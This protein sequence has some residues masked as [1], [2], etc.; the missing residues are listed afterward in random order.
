MGRDWYRFHR[1]Q[2]TDA[3]PLLKDPIAVFSAEWLADTFDM[4]VVV[5]IRHPGGFAAS[6]KRLGWTVEQAALLWKLIYYTLLQYRERRP[7][8]TF[9][10][11]EDLARDPV[12]AFGAMYGRLG[13]V[14]DEDAQATI[15]DHSSSGNPG[16][17]QEVH[18]LKR[19]SV[20]AVEAWRSQ[21]TD[22]EKMLVRSG[23]GDTAEAFYGPDDW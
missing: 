23:V 7:G 2:R 1:Y 4:N 15:V 12:G 14:L 3:R 16:A 5:M 18:Q 13:M 19:D 10:R 11:L 6:L 22:S 8:W 20:R 9:V 21:L 17:V